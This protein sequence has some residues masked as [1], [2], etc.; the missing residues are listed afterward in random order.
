MKPSG[1]PRAS[2]AAWSLV[3][4]PPRERPSPCSA[5]VVFLTGSVLVGPYG[6][7]ID[8][9]PFEIRVLQRLENALPGAVSA[10]A[11]EALEG[12]VPVAVA[13]GQIAPGSTAASDPEHSVDETAVVIGGASRVIGFTGEQVLNAEPVFVGDLL[14]EPS[15]S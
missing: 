8:H 1:L 2:T 12:R 5:A 3:V 11:I 10:P 9:K 6:R 4:K 15:V 14:R 13:L 7:R